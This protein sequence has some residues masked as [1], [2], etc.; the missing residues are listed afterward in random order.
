MT[1]LLLLTA[2]IFQLGISFKSSSNAMAFEDRIRCQEAIERVYYNHRIWP[3]ENPGP[4]PPFEQKISKTQ[5]EAKVEDYLKKSG[6]LEKFWQRPINAEQLQAEMDR[7]A[8]QTQDP[9]TLKELFAALDNDPYLIAECLARPVL[10]DRLVHNW[11]DSEGKIHDYQQL[12]PVEVIIEKEFPFKL[13]DISEASRDQGQGHWIHSSLSDVLDGRSGH[14]AVWTGSEMIVWGGGDNTGERYNPSTDSWIHTSTGANVPDGREYH[15]AVWTGKEM[16]VWGGSFDYNG[17]YCNTG[18]R[19]D[20]STDSWT[21]TSMGADVPSARYRHTA[22]WT[23]TEM[24]IWGGYSHTMLHNYFSTGGR[25]DPSSDAWKPTSTGA[26]VPSGRMLHTA[27]WS[28][29]EMIVWGGRDDSSVFNTGARYNPLTDSWIPTSTDANIPSPRGLHTAVWTGSE[30][31][32]WGG[33]GDLGYF[34]SGGRYNP[35]TDSWIPTFTGLNVPSRRTDHT[36]IWTGTEMIVWGGNYW[37]YP[38]DLYSNTGG[39]YDPST[40]SWNPTSTSTYVPAGRWYHT[41]VWT[42]TEMII[43]GG[44]ADRHH[45]VFNTG[46][47]YD[48]S[49]DSWVPTFVGDQVPSKRASHTAVWTGAEM[50]VWGGYDGASVLNTGGRY[51]PSTDSFLPTSTGANAPEARYGHTAV[52]T[53]MEVIV[54][55]GSNGDSLLDTGAR[56]NP[57]TD[58]WIS[59]STGAHHP[60]TRWDHTA[61]WTG[62]EMIVWGGL[63]QHDEEGY[64]VNTGARYEPISDSWIPTSTGYNVPSAREEH[65][66]VWT[67]T[68]MIVWGG[69]VLG[70][71]GPIGLSSGGRY[72]PLKD[73]WIPTSEGTDAPSGRAEH[74]VLW[75]GAEMIVWGGGDWDHDAGMIYTNTGARYDPSTDSWESTS[76]AGNAPAARSRHTAVW[77]GSEMIV[78]GG[79][80]ESGFTNTGGLYNP[81]KDSWVLTSSGPNEPSVRG[82]HTAVWNDSEMII[83]GGYFHA[84]LA[85]GGIYRPYCHTRPVE[86]P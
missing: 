61:V 66:A 27:I 68:E 71:G 26:N 22:V 32:I 51:Y 33:A 19:Y 18:G 6:A 86:K 29:S 85:S 55:G 10:A 63:E 21:P 28:G 60:S 42:G 34:N 50:V 79:I 16:I 9:E 5:I 82:G 64:F 35:S 52:W 72:D 75:T 73:S 25:Y 41:A 70:A 74:T 84:Y 37:S 23:G 43:W 36:A 59:T 20:P 17:P 14:T 31:I 53:G 78:W 77:T 39:R 45:I 81:F 56:Y 12:A 65:T 15:T 46:G 80:T 13:P 2:G 48:P 4:K 69:G 62:T 40:D 8:K 76:A 49:K 67:G 30:M 83:L 54:W 7:M 47:R 11:S 24:I 58:S 44:N 38:D 3:K 1:F 57:I